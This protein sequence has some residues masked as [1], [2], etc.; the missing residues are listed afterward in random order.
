MVNVEQ[1]DDAELATVRELVRKHV[2]ETGSR[3]GEEL[4]ANW[5]DTAARFSKIMPR[6]YK[7]VLTAQAKAARE[8]LDVNEQIMA[9]SH[10]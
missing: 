6:D 3:L 5:A 4:L 1:P 8:G 2:A 10:G 7:R 9:A